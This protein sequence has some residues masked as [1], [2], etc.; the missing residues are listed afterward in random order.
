[1]IDARRPRLEKRSDEDRKQRRGLGQAA[2]RH[3][4][5]E[6]GSAGADRDKLEKVTWRKSGEQRGDHEP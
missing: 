3:G 1:M 4:G 6:D 5:P 2:C